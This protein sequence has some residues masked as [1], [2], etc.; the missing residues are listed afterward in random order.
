MYLSW[1]VPNC[2]E[3]CPSSWIRDGYCDKPC[4]NSQCQW[5]GGD[6]TADNPLMPF[7]GP[8]LQQESVVTSFFNLKN[9]SNFCFIFSEN[10]NQNRIFSVPHC[11]K[12]IFKIG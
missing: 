11:L 12:Y 5:D 9:K 8:G 4:N 2:A 6:C 10:N 7:H 1:P 3:G